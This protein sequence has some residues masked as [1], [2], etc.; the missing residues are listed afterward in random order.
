MREGIDVADAQRS[1]LELTPVLGAETVAV[2][3][4]LGRVLAES[5]ESTRTLPPADCSAM[6]GYAVRRADLAGASAAEPR[7]LSVDFEVPA[8]AQPQRGIERGQ[9]ARIFTG[10]P[11]PPGTDAVVRQEDTETNGDR[12]RIFVDPEPREHVR[13]AGEELRIGDDVMPAGTTLRAAQ[14][15]GTRIS[16]AHRGG[17]PPA[18]ARGHPLWRRRARRARP[19]R[20]RGPNRLLQ[21]L[22]PGSHVPRDRRAA[23]LPGHR[24]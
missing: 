10:A 11:L 12:V 15:G 23:R 14:V 22:H 5:I 17:H 4:A 20:K 8:G 3:E 16:G 1:I 13:D 19:R 2:H 24:P 6:D 18:P 9:T 7:E 21:F